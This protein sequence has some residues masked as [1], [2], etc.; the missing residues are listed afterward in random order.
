MSLPT[1]TPIT[2]TENEEV[3]TPE[4]PEGT[5]AAE[6]TETEVEEAP[7]AVVYEGKKKVKTQEELLAYVAELEGQIPA[8]D[9]VPVPDD[10]PV[11]TELGAMSE[12]IVESEVPS[13]PSA[14][15]DLND[16]QAIVTELL[17]NPK[18]AV[19]KLTQKVLA[20]AEKITQAKEHK[21]ATWVKFYEAHQDL[22]AV[23]EDLLPLVFDKLV[24]SWRQEIKAGTRKTE[25]TWEE[26][27]KVLVSETRKLMKKF[28]GDGP[29][30]EVTGS[31]APTISSSGSPAP[32]AVTK[33]GASSNF[34][35]QV[36]SFQKKQRTG[37]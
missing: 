15:F 29:A 16:D 23:K 35:D 31:G 27:S 28:R 21:R 24:R 14:D 7:E 9:P 12:G 3:E 33:S 30:E 17:V 37:Q 26:G 19:A 34:T 8:E 36:R 13:Q 2:E 20:E 1:K 4:T 6:V 11:K 25:P 18:Q 5:E 10:A 22:E 32:H